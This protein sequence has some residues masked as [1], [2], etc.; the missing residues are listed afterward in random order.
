M[1]TTEVA[2]QQMW[3]LSGL[4]RFPKQP[5]AVQALIEAGL[6]F[7]TEAALREAVDGLL[8]ESRQCP[9]PADLFEIARHLMP[10]KKQRSTYKCFVCYDEGITYADF[11]VTWDANG[12]KTSERMMPEQVKAF[13]KDELQ[14]GRQG[15]YEF[16]VACVCGQ[17]PPRAVVA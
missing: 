4:D 6:A 9:K 5:L 3:R 14:T 15:I 13:P 10:E 12:K 1:I 7:P 8:R 17:K 2:R 11:L 16:P